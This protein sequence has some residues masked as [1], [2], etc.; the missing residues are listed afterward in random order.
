MPFRAD[1]SVRA[2]QEAIDGI[3]TLRRGNKL[4]GL[5]IKELI[6]ELSEKIVLLNGKSVR[7]PRSPE[8]H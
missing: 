6:E 4:G 1:M 2:R 7:I 5:T 3:R 8:G